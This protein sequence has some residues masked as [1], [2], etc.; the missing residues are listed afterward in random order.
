MK[1]KDK[2][3][4]ILVVVLANFFIFLLFHGLYVTIIGTGI[5][6]TFDKHYGLFTTKYLLKDT[7]LALTYQPAKLNFAQHGYSQDVKAWEDEHRRKYGG[8]IHE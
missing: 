6:P 8:H 1:L 5:N 2:L 7:D 3:F 4:A